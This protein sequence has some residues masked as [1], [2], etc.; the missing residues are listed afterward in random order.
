[1]F[2]SSTGGAVEQLINKVTEGV[3]AK[4]AEAMLDEYNSDEV[5]PCHALCRAWGPVLGQAKGGAGAG[6]TPSQPGLVQH[7]DDTQLGTSQPPP[8]LPAGVP[9]SASLGPN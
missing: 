7:G 4:L 8:S 5:G 2:T 9:R 3:A 1:M 6:G